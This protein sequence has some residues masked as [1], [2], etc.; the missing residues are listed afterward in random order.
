[1][2]LKKQPFTMGIK[3]TKKELKEEKNKI[4]FQNKKKLQRTL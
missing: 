4:K 1:M 3:K 2:N